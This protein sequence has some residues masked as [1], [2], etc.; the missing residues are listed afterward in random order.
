MDNGQY[1]GFEASLLSF[2]NILET[3]NAT[4]PPLESGLAAASGIDVALDSF[5]VAL[6][7]IDYDSIPGGPDD[8]VADLSWMWQYCSEYGAGL[9]SLAFHKHALIILLGFYQRGDPK[10]SLSIET[11]FLSLDL[12][13][14]QCNEAFPQGLPP[15]PQV[16]N[17][18]K[19][20]GWNMQ[21]SN[22]MFA[23]GE[24]ESAT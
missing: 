3:R 22:V 2:C 1:Y 15:T 19:Y 7:E 16:N 23:N 6:S 13:Q 12:F 21:P 8:P 17:V 24:C 5:L 10:N 18:N 14:Q 4:Q 9:S 11:S 20:G